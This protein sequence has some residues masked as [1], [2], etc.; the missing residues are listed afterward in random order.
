MLVT[1]QPVLRRFWYA[2]MPLA[3]LDAG[4]QPF[5]LLGEPIVVWRK[6]DG[7]VA[8]LR[9]RCCHRTAR[10]SR[11]FV[12]DSGIVCG[13]H[14]WT[15]DGDGR[16]VRI[17]QQPDTAIPAGA[18][19]PAYRCEARYG[20]A[21]VSLDAPLKPIFDIPEEHAPGHRRLQ[22][23]DETWQTG[24]LRLMENSFD[25]AHF[26]FV[27]RGTF[28]QFG[29]NRP[30]FFEIRQTDFGFV[31]E[32]R[33]V[34][35]NPPAAHRVTGTTDPTTV[36]HFHNE[37]HLPF[38]R[39]LG[40]VYPNGLAHTIYTC[41]TPIDD[42]RIRLIQW[43]YRNDTEDDCSAD[44]INAWDRRVVLEDKAV[45][46]G[47]DPDAPVDVSLRLEQNM[48]SDQPGLIMRRR[49]LELLRSHGERE[50]RGAA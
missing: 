27:H 22:Q 6:A 36:R 33:L 25:A 43:A 20:L 15:Y 45:L 47:V 48:V 32:T 34:I 38:S 16:C 41:A 42:T 28:G 30:D 23:F 24:A 10:L 29:K 19:V 1:K 18:C 39:R 50:Q 26:P 4:P 44:E 35:D 37:W 5:T 3:A 21:W 49:L 11:G 14:G 40:L 17:P 2:T 12:D 9:D 7:G 46:E 8:A 13:Y 31:A